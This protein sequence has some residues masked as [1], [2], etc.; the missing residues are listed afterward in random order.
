L[1]NWK[2]LLWGIA[3]QARNDMWCLGIAGQARNDMWCLGIA[4]L[5][6]NDE[7][8]TIFPIASAGCGFN[9]LLIFR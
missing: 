4:G 6:S 9:R 5:A 7:R 2:G 3:G 1:E 8:F